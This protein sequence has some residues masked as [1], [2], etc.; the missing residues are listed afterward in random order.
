M[1][2]L[3]VGI[4]SKI[5][6]GAKAT[7]SIGAIAASVAASVGN[8]AMVRASQNIF[9]VLNAVEAELFVNRPI[10]LLGGVS[11]AQ[12]R[13]LMSKVRALNPQRKN[14][15][16]V[17]VVDPKPPDLG[18]G[19]AGVD[20]LGTL[21]ILASDV[22]YSPGM[23]Q[24]SKVNIGGAAM[25]SVNGIEATE[26]TITTLDDSVGT[27][28]RWFLGKK[29]QMVNADG[30]FGL[31]ADYCVQIEIVHGA[32]TEDAPQAEAAFRSHFRMRPSSMPIELSRRDHGHAEIQLGFSQ[33]DSFYSLK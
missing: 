33:F 27:L 17:R 11:P 6:S 32:P 23:V 14:L 18:G 2:F 9:G 10:E 4:V 28:K 24:G 16:F 12:A 29:A 7:P 15:W 26:V 22:S 5:A 30:T 8:D 13:D 19:L 1:S 31:P 20:P 21:A 3:D 25:D